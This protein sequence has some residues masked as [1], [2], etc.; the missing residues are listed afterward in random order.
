MG[1]GG[2]FAPRGNDKIFIVNRSTNYPLYK[3]NATFRGMLIDSFFYS[4]MTL[5]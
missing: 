2:D 1:G 4:I 3:S 5:L